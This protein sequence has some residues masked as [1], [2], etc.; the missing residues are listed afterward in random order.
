MTGLPMLTI[1]PEHV[2][3]FRL[4]LRTIETRT[5]A[6]PA[7]PRAALIGQRIGIH[8]SKRDPDSAAARRDP[9]SRRAL[10]AIPHGDPL[11]RGAI[12]LTGRLARCVPVVEWCEGAPVPHLCFSGDDLLLHSPFSAP[13]P[14]GQTGHVVSDQLPFGDFTPG[15]FGWLLDDIKPTTEQCPW[16]WGTMSDPGRRNDADFYLGIAEAGSLPPCPVCVGDDGYPTG[17]CDPIPATGRQ[18]IWRFEP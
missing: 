11:T 2:E 4:G 7:A 5:W 1:H 15:N 16:C 8:A 13:W 17:H 18:G 6:P 3:L 12:V 9:I 10:A 14:D